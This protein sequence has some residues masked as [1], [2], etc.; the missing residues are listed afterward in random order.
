VRVPRSQHGL[1]SR[2]I[3]ETAVPAVQVRSPRDFVVAR[4]GAREV[5]PRQLNV[6]PTASRQITSWHAPRRAPRCRGVPMDHPQPTE[7]L[8]TGSRARRSCL[9]ASR[10]TAHHDGAPYGS[11]I[12]AVAFAT[13]VDDAERGGEDFIPTVWGVALPPTLS[14]RSVATSPNPS[15]QAGRDDRDKRLAGQPGGS[16]PV[17]AGGWAMHLV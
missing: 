15:W 10:S 14:R 6:D 13:P 2:L 17:E 11:V 1:C 16:Q 9:T 4:T 8:T 7:A 12:S 3:R 5:R